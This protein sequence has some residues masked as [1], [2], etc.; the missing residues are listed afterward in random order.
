MLTE[1]NELQFGLKK[2]TFI[3]IS[4]PKGEKKGRSRW[5]RKL[6]ARKNE[7]DYVLTDFSFGFSWLRIWL[8]FS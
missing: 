8:D 7:S 2:I 6:K 3:I 5:E 4:I 1:L